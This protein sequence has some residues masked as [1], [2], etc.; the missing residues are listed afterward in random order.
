MPNNARAGAPA[1]GAAAATDRVEVREALA[2]D[3]GRWDAFVA[4]CPEATFFHR[5]GWSRVVSEAHGHRTWFLLA[6]RNGSVEGVL[7]L[8]L[9]TS[10]IFGKALI[11]TGFTVG[12]GIAATGEAARALLAER[13]VEIGREVGVDYVELRS[14]Q[15]ELED[16]LVKDGT[17][18]VSR[19]V[20]SEDEDENLK[21]IPRKK[22]ADVRKA[23][24]SDLTVDT[25]VSLEEV[26]A[27]YAE[28]QRNHGTPVF[29]RRFMEAILREFPE[30]TEL[31]L[32]RKDGEGLA[33]LLSFYFRDQVMPYYAGATPAARPHHAFDYLYWTLM[34]RA[35]ARGA[36]VFDFGRSKVGT[37]SCDYKKFWGF[38]PEPLSYQYH[39][40]KA[41]E[42]PDVNPLN[43]KYRLM[44]KA[45]QQLPLALSRR[46]GPL[47]ARQLG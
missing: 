27:L 41:R 20:L 42:L 44:V 39:L 10:P 3:G 15:A 40:V 34:Q 17:Y 13:A 33:S 37:G 31:S 45:W 30:E 2:E 1:D 4:A 43:P 29:S 18:V 46:V 19:R 25:D 7:P 8:V 47:V 24:K 12:G 21:A 28:S 23:I 38:E 32:V 14:E 5:F 26:Y 36:R 22:R 6:E 16:W 9:V 35:V 11:S